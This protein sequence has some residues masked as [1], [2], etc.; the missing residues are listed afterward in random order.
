MSRRSII[1]LLLALLALLASIASVVWW[2]SPAREARERLEAARA[3]ESTPRLRDALCAAPVDEPASTARASA[4]EAQPL[5]ATIVAPKDGVEVRVVLRSNGEPV[6]GARVRGLGLLER[7]ESPYGERVLPVGVLDPEAELAD[8]PVYVTDEAGMTRVPR[9]SLPADYSASVDGLWGK[10]YFSD[11]DKGPFTIELE[12]DASVRVQVVD[13]DGRA[14]P[15]FPVALSCESSLRDDHWS[16]FTNSTGWIEVRHWSAAV[17]KCLAPEEAC[18]RAVIL[19]R[20]DE[21]IPRLFFDAAR[22][23]SE[24]LKLMLPPLG[25]VAV[26][27]RSLDG[28]PLLAED[29]HLSRPEDVGELG[30][31]QFGLEV[32]EPDDNEPAAAVFERVGLGIDVCAS[33]WHTGFKA[34]HVVGRG[35]ARVGETATIDLVVEEPLPIVLGRLVDPDGRPLAS[36]EAKMTWPSSNDAASTLTKDFETNVDGRFRVSV[37][38]RAGAWGP[39]ADRVRFEYRDAMGLRHRGWPKL[40]EMLGPRENDLGDVRFAP[41]R[42]LARGVV[43]DERG[44]PLSNPDV[45]VDVHGPSNEDLRFE[46]HIDIH[47]HA[48]GSFEVFGEHLPARDLRW[49]IAASAQGYERSE[50]SAFTPGARDSRLQLGLGGT[51]EGNVEFVPAGYAYSK[52]VLLRAPKGDPERTDEL[53]CRLDDQGHFRFCASRPGTFTLKAIGGH[54]QLVTLDG[55]ELVGGKACDDPRLLKIVVTTPDGRWHR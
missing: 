7:S 49:E 45:F 15:G 31:P 5:V 42:E 22:G 32:F 37:G 53:H 29:L 52:V 17:Q 28:L 12:P 24:P 33:T 44:Q 50:S 11:G 18:L 41:M 36:H 3:S 47:E 9:S 1:R 21:S 13:A 40:A 14:A 2:H 46:A 51:L 25:R 39:A 6:R 38:R 35:P 19:A 48:D 43:L 27:A 34:V 8:T 20:D 54:D 26:R 23:S 10:S 16:A 55:L 4:V 30:L